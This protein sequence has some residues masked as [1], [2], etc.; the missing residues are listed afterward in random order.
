M[1]EITIGI[2]AYNAHK[3]IENT[4]LS[5]AMQHD[6]N[7]AKIIIIDDYSDKGYDDVI[8][9]F[10]RWVDIDLIRLNKNSGPGTARNHIIQLCQTPYLAFIDADDVFISSLFITEAI[11]GFRKNKEA[12]VFCSLMAEEL[13]NGDLE[14]K[15]DF[16]W[17]HGKAYLT[18]FLKA[19]EIVFPDWQTIGD[20]MEDVY[21]NLHVYYAQDQQ[22]IYSNSINYMYKN[23]PDSLVRSYG[24]DKLKIPTVLKEI[25]IKNMLF[26]DSNNIKY[27]RKI[28]EIFADLIRY[29]TYANIVLNEFLSDV[30]ST[31]PF[32]DALSRL[33][34]PYSSGVNGL[35]QQ[36]KDL[37]YNKMKEHAIRHTHIL[38]NVENFIAKIFNTK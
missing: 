24:K 20:I 34:Q 38:I 13:P 27:E 33:I 15:N 17:L 18:S 36:E 28:Q 2:P 1:K 22:I 11:E 12:V 31:I 21:F 7:K 23:N 29:Y 19:K 14:A 4:L 5:I 35:L 30:K 3:T 8:K 6:I 16:Y 32:W 25:E 9:I 26:T 10:Q 37:Y